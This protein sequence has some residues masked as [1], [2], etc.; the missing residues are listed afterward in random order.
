M[1]DPNPK[2]DR[3]L[4]AFLIAVMVYIGAM[5]LWKS[6]RPKAERNQALTPNTFEMPVISEIRSFQLTNQFNLPV[7][8]EALEGFVW[9]ADVI[10][11]RCPG[12]C[13]EL[14]QQMRRIQDRLPIG[15]PVRLISLT[16]D[17]DY[18]SP[19][20]LARYARRYGASSNQWYFLTGTKSEVYELAI[21]SLKFSV[22]ET[23]ETERATVHD[24]FIHSSMFGIV[25]QKGRMR[26]VVQGEEP[27][28]EDQVLR[29]VTTLLSELRSETSPSK[30]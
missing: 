18:D 12:M 21:D 10:F 17:P 15:A 3:L 25:D 4:W 16:A 20:V 24:L 26:A 11:S 1:S 8:R 23:A 28:A 7:S 2:A 14:S 22:L 27:D 6:V 5:F 13:H 30:H 29:Y 19:E 9:V